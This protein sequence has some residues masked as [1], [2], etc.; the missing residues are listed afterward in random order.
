MSEPLV[1]EL[2]RSGRLAG[3]QVPAAEAGVDLP[4]EVLRDSRPQLPEVSELDAVR[5]Y[6][7]L[8]QR[9]FSI[10]TQF[11]PLGS[12][13]MKYNPRGCNTYA[14]LP[15]FLQRHPLAPEGVSQGFLAC[16][17]ELQRMLCRVTGMTAFSLTP[18]AGAQGELSGVAM[19]RAY[20][21]DRGDTERTEILVPDAA[22]G[23]NPATAVKCGYTV[24]ELSTAADGDLD[25]DALRRLAG[26]RTAGIMLTNPSTLGLFERRIR[27]VEE[28]I[29]GAGGL[30]YYD[31][32][33]L[34]A[35]LGK[36]L[37]GDMGFD[38]IHINLHK[39]FSTP[40]GGGGP[41]SGAVGVGERLEPYLPTPFVGIGPDGYRWV[42]AADHPKSI[43]RLSAF[44]G[45]A[46]VLLRA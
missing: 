22:H 9:N 5:H 18:M 37:P 15:G 1:F 28:I 33:N 19:I 12:C 38:V 29:H 44:M 25:I 46:G 32:A 23:T 21:L 16:M 3:A 35:I 30:L 27:E 13:T 41:G 39:T 8:S 26:P 11:Y 24:R 10:D 7:R 42:D 36:V 17:Y 2:G 43:G 14:M 6:T 45:N 20:H 40:H 31:G 34:N 4:P